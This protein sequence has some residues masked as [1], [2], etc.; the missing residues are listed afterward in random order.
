M[1]LQ[2]RVEADSP[3]DLEDIKLSQ[4]QYHHEKNLENSHS[5]DQIEYSYSP[6]SLQQQIQLPQNLS[7]VQR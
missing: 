7:V 1:E 4:P 3:I 2:R 5:S 6:L